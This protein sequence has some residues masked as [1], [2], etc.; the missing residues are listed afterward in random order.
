MIISVWRYSHLALAVSSFLL[1]TLASLTGIILAFEPVLEK[2][3]GYK[4]DGFDTITLA[5]SI[6][7]LRE[8]LPGLQEIKIDD[9]DF[10]IARFSDEEANDKTVYIHPITGE[11]LGEPK[12]QSP[13]FKW[14]TALHRSLFLHETGRLIVGISSFFL[15]LIALTGV[16]LIIKRQKGIRRFF[17][18]I[19][20]TSFSQYYHTVFGRAVLLFIL[21]LALTGTYL[22]VSRFILKP[23]IKSPVVNEDTIKEEPE[24]ALQDFPVFKQTKLLQ[25]E[26]I[27]FPFSDFP[28]DYFTLKLKDR[29]VA[30]NQFTSDVLAQHVYPTSHTLTSFSLRWH[31]G[32]SNAVWAIIMAIT[33]AYI[34]F[35]IYSGL[36]ITRKRMSGLIKNR[37]KAADCSTIILVGSENGSTF[38]FASAIYKQF[39]KKGEKA[40]L[41][42]LNKY[43]LYPKASQFIIMTSTYGEGDPPTNAQKF[44]EALQSHPQQRPVLFSV[45]GFG[46]RNYVHFCK[47]AHDVQ[48]ALQQQPWATSL[49][50]VMTVNDNSP[51]D[52]SDWLTAYNQHTGLNLTIPRQLLTHHT[53]DLQQLSVVSKKEEGEAFIIQL[54][55]KGVK[56][57]ASGDLLAIYPKADHRERLYSIGRVNGTIQL[58]VKY[59]EQGLGSTYLSF[60]QQG[61]QIKARILKNQ[62]FHFPNKAK[63][64]LMVCNGTGIA[65]FLGMISD[66]KARQSCVLYCGFRTKGSFSLY[67]DFLKGQVNNK[68]LEQYQLALSREGEKQYVCHLLE[69]DAAIVK[70]VLTSGGAIMICG[71]LAMQRDVLAVIEAIITTTTGITVDEYIDKGQILTDCY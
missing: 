50:E 41:T 27:Q 64:V 30:V 22:S 32:R 69:R 58:S 25:V 4:A 16:A 7:A 26:S 42:D 68:K 37:Y 46:S 45:V 59:H 67:E 12:E 21:A 52:F 39:V 8:K 17:A 62:H 19:E 48:H 5:Q 44:L 57:A 40:F 56:K 13:F 49:T 34:L 38:R 28:E 23:T 33:S 55:G 18:P 70:E 20:R 35:F 61:Q 11:V 60:L 53:K 14:V 24:L 36:L 15:I 6:P 71:S 1:L 31:T 43:T 54:Q 51:Q 3:K 2:A 66:N 10:V 9:H 29:E 63:K 47:F 65:P